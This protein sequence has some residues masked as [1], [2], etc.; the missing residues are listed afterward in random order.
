MLCVV[1]HGFDESWRGVRTYVLG[2]VGQGYY[3]G[4]RPS[5]YSHSTKSWAFASLGTFVSFKTVRS[6][7]AVR[8]CLGCEAFLVSVSFPLEEVLVPQAT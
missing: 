3:L 7:A 6:V 1:L 8:P 5:E 2:L 4:S